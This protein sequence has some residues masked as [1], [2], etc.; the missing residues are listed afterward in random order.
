VTPILRACLLA[1]VLPLATLS[2][3]PAGSDA[4]AIPTPPSAAGYVVESGD[5]VFR[6]GTTLLSLAVYAADRQASYSHVGIAWVDGD[7][8]WV[9]HAVPAEGKAAGGVVAEPL[10]TFVRGGAAS[11]FAIHRLDAPA[12]V[13]RAAAGAALRHHRAAVPFD[14]AFD[15]AED[16]S[17]YCTELVW[18]VYLDQGIDLTR[19]VRDSVA[20]PFGELEVLF[21]SRLLADP[22]LRRLSPVGA[23]RKVPSD[24]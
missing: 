15:L 8:G 9:V 24:A 7:G 21:T 22:R 11:G 2:G 18:R 4:S 3:V 6:R 1:G 13:R 17:L 5:L 14:S 19:G 10:D 23:E 12:E 16:R 20:T